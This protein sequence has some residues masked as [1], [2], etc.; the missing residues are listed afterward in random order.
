MLVNYFWMFCEGLHLHL[1]LVVVSG[2]LWSRGWL[3]GWMAVAGR[4]WAW[5]T[6]T[7]PHWHANPCNCFASLHSSWAW[8]VLGRCDL[9]FLLF[10]ASSQ[11][12]L[13]LQ[14]MWEQVATL[15][16]WFPS[17]SSCQNYPF[18]SPHFQ[19]FVK[20]TIVMRWFI[21]I[22]WLS[23]VHF[24]VVY[25]LARHFSSTDNEQW[26]WIEEIWILLFKCK[27]FFGSCWINDSLY[28]WIFSVPI[29]LSLLAS[30][31]ELTIIS[32]HG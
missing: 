5:A 6:P 24:A 19:V 20:D 27:L 13:P 3:S 7:L 22:S 8:A 14:W 2:G 26:A 17:L 21:I 16:N 25:G 10:P 9:L 23:P 32:C 1:V 29:T 30:F 4:P 28:L 15:A 18:F 31:S 11:W 12:F